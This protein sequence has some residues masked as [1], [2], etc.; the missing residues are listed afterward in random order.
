MSRKET[1]QM[2]DTFDVIVLGM[3]PGGEVAAS[4]LLAAGRRVAVIER[5]LIGGECAYWACIPSKTLLRPPEARAEADRAAGV[6]R[7]ALHWPAL[8]DYRDWMIRHLDDSGQITGYEKQG[9][10][11]VKGTGRLAGRT[12]DGLLRVQAGGQ[13]LHAAHVIVATGSEPLRPPVDGLADVPVWTNREATT[14]ADIPQRVLILGGSAV[15]VELGPFLARMGAP[16]TLIE[17][18]DR[19]VSREEPR[20]G[21]LTRAALHA[22]GID[23]RLGRQARRATRHD[24]GT[25]VELD[26]GSTVDVDVVV[27]GTGRRPR[28]HDLGLDTVGI[29]ET[30]LDGRGLP[31]DEHCRFGDGLWAVGD[32]T[33]RALF[34]HVAKYQARVAAD[35]ICGRP[36]RAAYDGIPR[37]IFADPEIAAVGMTTATARDRGIH[38]TSVEVDLP[39]TIARPWTYETNPRGT[40]GLLVD[41]HQRV[42]VGA[43]AVA[44]LAGEWIHQAALAVRAAVPVD[45]L[46]DQ[47]AQFPTYTEAYLSAL[48]QM[49]L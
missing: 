10:T 14:L 35:T 37:V 38:V 39:A 26:D 32:V 28:V 46:L 42:L 16:V 31:V 7:P 6:D 17:R 25:R 41:P 5:E 9:A 15:A 11:V 1:T 22:D 44:P 20:V 43:W 47:V 4:R 21:E 48:E 13:T 12:G 40:L 24:H 30:A 19:L 18:G 3:G 49:R 2:T 23:V 29:D 36:R 27:L 45:I 34:T 8:R 33:G